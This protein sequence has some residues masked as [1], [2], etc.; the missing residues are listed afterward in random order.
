MSTT[1]QLRSSACTHQGSVRK[2]NQDAFVD[3]PEIGLWAVADGAGG[4]GGGEI[5]SRMLADALG[6]VPAGLSAAHL[7]AEVRTRIAATN[8]AL[9]AL[10]ASR[11]PDELVAATI[12]ALM[13]HGEH[14]AVLWAGDARCYRLRDGNLQQVTRD[15][16]LV[17][18]LVDAGEITEED[19]LR[20]PRA[21]VVTRAVG[22]D[23]DIVLDKAVDRLVPGDLFLL[24][25]DGVDK[26]LD[27]AALHELLAGGFTADAAE[28]VVQAA[29]AR[30]ARDNVTAVVVAA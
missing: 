11:G 15:H 27:E 18:E 8:A 14:M 4:H 2:S 25:S 24:C 12:V 1:L 7:L 19:A 10:A 23:D 6:N 9:R 3:R 17:Q 5:A 30:T 29:L 13:A 16:S 22:A 26:T 28:R 21:N 20:H